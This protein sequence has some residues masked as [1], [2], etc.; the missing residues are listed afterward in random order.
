MA[1]WEERDT[2][3]IFSFNEISKSEVIKLISSLSNSE[4]F[5]QD[6]LDAAALKSVA[7]EI[8][9]PVQH[10]INVS[11]SSGRFA[12]KWKTAKVTPRLKSTSLNKFLVS[13]YRPVAILTTVS[14]L[15]EKTA[16]LLAFL[17]NTNQLNDSNHAYRTS[18]S[19]TT[20]L[21]EITDKLFQGVEERE[22]IDTC[23]RPVIHVR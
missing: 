20:T 19:T 15:V 13:S 18:L 4:A 11:L 8:S 10:I 14:K 1:G 6:E 2:R 7:A 17:E 23:N 12:Q 22:I 3:P 5:G 21:A 9:G 16:Q